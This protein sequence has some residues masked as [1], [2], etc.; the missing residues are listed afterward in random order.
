MVEV[1]LNRRPVQSTRI[2][3]QSPAAIIPLRL[4]RTALEL[5]NLCRVNRSSRND[6]TATEG[7]IAS[8]PVINS[9]PHLA[10]TSQS[11]CA[12]HKQ[13]HIAVHSIS[14]VISCGTNPVEIASTKSR[15]G[16]A[17]TCVPVT[18]HAQRSASKISTKWIWIRLSLRE[19]RFPLHT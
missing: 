3:S 9:I 7:D 5:C 17:L 4:Y 1:Y 10:R 19:R 15:Q 8:V 6:A 16:L 14:P 11:P 12:S 13:I 18:S 2:I